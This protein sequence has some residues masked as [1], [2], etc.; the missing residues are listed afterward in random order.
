[1]AK[2]KVGRQI[3]NLT[4]NHEKLRIDPIPSRAGGVQHAIEKLSTKAIASL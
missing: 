3:G 4:P 1:M 2:R